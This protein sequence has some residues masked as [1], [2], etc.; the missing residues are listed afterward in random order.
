M[1]EKEERPILKIALSKFDKLLELVS[2]ILFITLWI[3]CTLELINLPN[4]IPIHFDFSGKPDNY[5]S[6]N[7]LLIL[8]II[9]S[10]V[11][12][13]F[14]YL[15]KRPHIFN[16]PSKITKDNAEQQYKLATQMLRVLKIGILFLGNIIL[17]LLYT[18]VTHNNINLGYLV[19]PIIFCCV[20]LPTLVYV[21][22]LSKRK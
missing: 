4:I 15:C 17:C 12:I 8:P 1:F 20:L 16:Y 7:T 11:A 21:I 6:K 22:K 13:L 19:L 9:M 5:G 2:L 10:L 3:I 18:T 14:T